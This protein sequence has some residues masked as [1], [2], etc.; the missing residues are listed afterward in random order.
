[1]SEIKKVGFIGLGIM[2]SSMAANLLKQG[3]EV[4]VYNRSVEKTKSLVSK[5]AVLQESPKAVAEN[6]DTILFCVTN[7]E[8]LEILIFGDNGVFRA[9]SLP[10]FIVDFSTVPPR[11]T[12]SIAERVGEK[13]IAFLDAP[14]SGGDIG[15]KNG[16]LS[17]MVGAASVS[18]FETMMPVFQAVGATI[19]HVGEV[20]CGQLTKSV[21]QLVVGTTVA[22]MTEGLMLAEQS[23]LNLETTLKVLTGGAANSWTLEN[24][25]PRVVTGDLGPG[26][27]A[28]DMLKDLRISLG[29]ADDKDLVLPIS[30][31]VKELFSALC[32]GENQELGS[33][34]LIQ[35]YQQVQALKNA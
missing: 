20:G 18:D 13:G 3:F 34:A 28:K 11:S 9:K 8:A 16:S 26:F 1:M 22:A 35:V 6:S 17:V 30:A 7:D 10:R 27:Y 32:S 19:T 21:N 15:A 24:L 29:V 4:H 25:G 2:G 33:H 23:G 14:V 31:M 5:G 12:I